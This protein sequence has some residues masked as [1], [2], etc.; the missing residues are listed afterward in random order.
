MNEPTYRF[1]GFEGPLDVLLTLIE[2]HK[3]D[4]YNV[5]ISLLLEQYL[6]WLDEARKNDLA[7]TA[8]FLEMAS[9]LVY[10][11]SCSLLPKHDGDE[12]EDPKLLL[13]QMLIEYAKYK[14]IALKLRPAYQG[15]RIWFRER[16]PEDLPKPDYAENNEAEQLRKTY[17]RLLK[18]QHLRNLPADGAFDGIV[19]TQ[20]ISVGEKIV[21][22]LRVLIRKAKTPFSSVFR[23]MKSRSEIVATFLALLE[24]IRNGRVEV[25]PSPDGGESDPQIKLIRKKATSETPL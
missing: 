5:E 24:L 25:Q 9:R 11:K 12:E 14:R 8:D 13:E 16:P 19:R 1:D 4:I 15:D 7:V 22:V 20:F 17:R 18:K 23:G 2:R 3:I 6:A 10:V 21:S